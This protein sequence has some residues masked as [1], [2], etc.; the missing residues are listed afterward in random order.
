MLKIWIWIRVW[1]GGRVCF[2]TFDA[3][4]AFRVQRA[5]R[6]AAMFTNEV[7]CGV[8]AVLRCMGIATKHCLTAPNIMFVCG[9]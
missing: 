6:R 7:V 9:E 8:E 1:L 3:T 2:L 4:K 5:K